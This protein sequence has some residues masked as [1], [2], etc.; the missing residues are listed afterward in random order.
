MKKCPNCN[1]F[2]LY[3]DN[4]AV[5]PICDARLT[6]YTRPGA[7][8]ER[9]KTIIMPRN[10]QQHQ[11][12]S[13]SETP[14][15]ETKQG[16]RYVYR[17]MITEINHHARFHNRLKKWVFAFF[18]G[19]P[20]QFGNTSHGSVVRIEEF[21]HDRISG[22]KRDLVFYGDVEGRFNYGDDVTVIA[23]RRGDRYIVTRMYLNETESRVRPTPQ[24]PSA[25]I[26][27]FSLLL[28]IA[29][30]YLLVSI[31]GFFASGAFLVLLQKLFSFAIVVLVL[32]WIARALFRRD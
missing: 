19:E 10:D 22:R 17:G 13:G 5:C 21:H 27:V 28:L 1:D 30:V 12:Q 8:T 11:E 26:V 18:R 2:A 25:I 4:V 15:F 31:A 9:D 24:I 16:L 20:Y 29:V 7:A 3:D 32:F 6:A 14:Q 23:K